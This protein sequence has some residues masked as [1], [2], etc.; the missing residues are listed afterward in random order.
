MTAKDEILDLMQDLPDTPNYAEVF[1]SLRPLY[2]QAVAPIIA[3]YGD[4]PCP[5]GQW[6]RDI[7]GQTEAEEQSRVHTVKTDLVA[8][9]QSLPTRTSAAETVD[10]AMY[11]L[12]QSYSRDKAINQIAEGQGI[13]HNKV[14]RRIACWRGSTALNDNFSR[15]SNDCERSNCRNYARFARRC[16]LRG[17]DI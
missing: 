7:T 2:N 14:R 3:Q 5:Q 9:M 16:D 15:G 1:N 8:L 17:C 4:P 10:H 13:P 6:R 12:I 11:E